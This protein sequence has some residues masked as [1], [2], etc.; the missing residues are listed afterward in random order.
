LLFLLAMSKLLL[1]S[2]KVGRGFKTSKGFTLIEA[3]VTIS[4]IGVLAALVGPQ[5]LAFNKPLQNGTNQVVGILRQVRMRAIANTTAYRLRRSNDTSFIVESSTTRG[6]GSVTE[7]RLPAIAT[8]TVL[9]VKSARGF[10]IGDAIKIGSDETG[11]NI[12]G[13]DT[14]NQTITLGGTGLGSAQAADTSVELIDNWRGGDLVTG[15]TQDDLTLPQPRSAVFGSIQQNPSEQV[16][17]QFETGSIATNIWDASTNWNLCFNSV[18]TANLVNP[19]NG[20][21]LNQDLRI[22][23]QRFNTETSTVL[24]TTTISVTSGGSL[25]INPADTLKINQ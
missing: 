6:C 9:R 13:T 17:M 20:S 2:S 11:N 10:F 19:T 12:T 3:L 21:P 5:V 1:S 14:T 23:L 15:F 24:G 8:D 22:T 25:Q 4:I 18:G 7:L 16:R